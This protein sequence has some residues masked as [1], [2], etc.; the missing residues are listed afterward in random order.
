MQF[1]PQPSSRF[2]ALEEIQGK[3]CKWRR[4]KSDHAIH[5]PEQSNPEPDTETE[6]TQLEAP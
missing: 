4:N 3:A 1:M 2:A 6:I 5:T